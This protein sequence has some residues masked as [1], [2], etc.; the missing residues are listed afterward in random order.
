[1][2]IMDSFFSDFNPLMQPILTITRLNIGEACVF[3]LSLDYDANME[4]KLKY[5]NLIF[6]DINGAR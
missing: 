2:V 3:K 1:M 5:F 6:R 4:S